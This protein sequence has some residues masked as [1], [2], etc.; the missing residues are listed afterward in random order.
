MRAGAVVEAR[1]RSI[2]YCFVFHLSALCWKR[3]TNYPLLVYRMLFPHVGGGE[4][5]QFR[6]DTRA[7]N[8]SFLRKEL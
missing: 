5:V 3:P 4:L 1:D 7:Y 8:C 2:K 6:I